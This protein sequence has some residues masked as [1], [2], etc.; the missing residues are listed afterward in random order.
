MQPLVGNSRL[1]RLKATMNSFVLIG[2]TTIFL[3]V[4]I[5][6]DEPGIPVPLVERNKDVILQLHNDFRRTI[7]AADMKELVSLLI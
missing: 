1:L 7:Y 5:T 6:A 4:E 3:I 2:I